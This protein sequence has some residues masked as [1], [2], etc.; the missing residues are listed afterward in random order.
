MLAVGAM[1]LLDRSRD[2][3][4]VVEDVIGSR[5]RQHGCSRVLRL[6]FVILA[7]FLTL[8]PR[9]V[10]VGPLFFHWRMGWFG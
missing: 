10:H 7:L 4:F 9:N 1:R 8:T 2:G 3:D 6:L 5:F